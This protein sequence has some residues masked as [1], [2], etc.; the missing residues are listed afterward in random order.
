MKFKKGDRVMLSVGVGD[1]C[2]D[3]WEVVEDE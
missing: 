2:P 3:F 1:C